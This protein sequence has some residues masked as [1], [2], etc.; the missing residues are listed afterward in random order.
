MLPFLKET[1]RLEG[2]LEEYYE[3]GQIKARSNYKDGKAEGLLELWYPN[4]QPQERC[5]YKDGKKDENSL[6]DNLIEMVNLN[7]AELIIKTT[8][9][10]LTII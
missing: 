7:I 8:I 1:Q 3:N 5:N 6:I 10:F 2:R 4:G 9:H